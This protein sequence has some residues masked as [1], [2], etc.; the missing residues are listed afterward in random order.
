MMIVVRPRMTSRRPARIRAS[1]V[2]STD[3]VASSR[4][5]MRGS[6]RSARAIAMRCRCPP[7]SVIPRSPI[8][9]SYPCGQVFD[10]EVMGLRRARRRLDRL[11]RSVR[12]AEGDVVAHRRREEKRILGDDPDLAAQRPTLN[13]SD[14]GTVHEHTAA[15]DLVEAR[16]ERGQ[17]GLAGASSADQRESAAGRDLE[18]DVFEDETAG[19]VAEV[20]ILEANVPGPRRERPRPGT[21]GDLLRL[22]ENLEDALARRG[23]PLRLTDPH[24]EHA[25]RHHEHGEQ[26]E[27]GEEVA[28]G[29]R[30]VDHHSPGHEKN[31][32]LGDEWEKAEQRHVERA[33][34]VCRERVLEDRVGR[35]RELLSP[36][37]L[38]R[39]R[40][41]HVHPDDAL[42]RHR[43]DICE[44]RLHIA[45]HRMRDAAVALSDEDD[46][47][48]D[49]ERDESELPAVDEE[50]SRDDDDGHHV[51][52]EE[53]EPV[54]EEEAHR[55]QVD[56]RPGHELPRLASVVEAEREA[57][58]VRVELV[59]HVVL[60]REGLPSGK[61][62]PPEHQ[63]AAHEPERHDRTDPPHENSGVLVSVEL[64]DHEPD[65]DRNEDP[66]DLR[67]D[68]EHRRDG[69]RGAVRAEEREQA[70]EGPPRGLRSRRRVLL[71]R[72]VLVG[73]GSCWRQCR[74]FPRG[75]MRARSRRS[76][77]R[78]R[79]ARSSSTSIRTRITI[80]RS[81]PLPERRRT[82]VESLLAGIARA[83][84]LVDLRVHDGVHPRVGAVDVVPLVH[85]VP[86]E[87]RWPRKPRSPSPT[88]S[89]PS[90]SSR[91]SC[92]ERSATA[93]GRRSSAPE[94]S[95]SSSGACEARELRVDAGP[96][97][98]DPR[99]GAVLVGA[100]P[101]LV[102]Y[103]LDLR[104]DDVGVARAI[105]ASIRESGGGM[106]GVQAI[107]LELKRAAVAS[108]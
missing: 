53:D 72:H 71:S 73:Y 64:V 48:R 40:L 49:R 28:R 51:L 79:A 99:V 7:D 84:E 93:S 2:A 77:T 38:L 76:D 60:D 4:T 25:E 87:S 98:L 75:E 32:S 29:H 106:P 108:R 10:D 90:S 88:A 17:G 36:T 68:R 66:C 101:P 31:G 69:E 27:E 12:Q 56:R 81:S 37:L 19:L 103:N 78:S 1:V 23:R 62:S 58:E 102:A 86:S 30:S 100:R 14:V 22:V 59:T 89:A 50:H 70:Y 97:R 5:R 63:R 91:C 43:R 3:A 33:L 74:T 96:S 42:L 94:A 16:N 9:V 18:I 11:V 8:T 47:R 95:S 104:T 44:L 15:R 55:L 6:I 107:G 39:E 26:Q 57:Q 13:V 92:T 80:A 24:S 52:R 82:L 85:L 20:D 45:K 61:Q 34:T 46:R 83:L 54:S 67:S 65:Q 21:V 35:A 105:A 41:D